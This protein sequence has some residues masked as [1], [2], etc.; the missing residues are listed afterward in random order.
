MDKFELNVLQISDTHIF[1]DPAGRLGGMV[2]SASFQKV[3]DSALNSPINFDLVL[4][5]G[6]LTAESEEGA[7]RWLTKELAV[8]NVVVACIPGNHDVATLMEPIVSA[9]GWHYCGDLIASQ[10]HFILL[11]SAVPGADYGGLSES[12]LLRLDRCLNAHS[13]MPTIV[14]LHHNPVPMDCRWID[15]M[16]LENAAAFWNVIDQH[17]HVRSVVWGHVHQ[18]YDSFRHGV[19]LLATPS[20]CVQFDARSSGFAQAPLAPGFRHLRLTGDGQL[21]TRVVRLA[22]DRPYT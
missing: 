16:T 7:Y 9:A 11:D 14:V 20:T 5:T 13:S 10:W 3:L 4:L 22:N 17:A 1:A 8:L 2:T 12:E 15:T 6:D 18:N 21:S 19:R